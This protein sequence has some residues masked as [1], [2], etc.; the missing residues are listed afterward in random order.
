MASNR[1]KGREVDSEQKTERD[2]ARLSHVYSLSGAD[3]SNN[4]ICSL[5]LGN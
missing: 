2:L 4:V 3:V 5:T 1:T